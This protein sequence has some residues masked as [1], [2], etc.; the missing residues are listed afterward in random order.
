LTCIVKRRLKT[1]WDVRP[2][3]KNASSDW[4]LIPTLSNDLETIP[5]PWPHSGEA[6]RGLTRIRE[7]SRLTCIVKR[8]LKTP[9][10]VRPLIKKRNW[11]RTGNRIHGLEISCQGGAQTYCLPLVEEGYHL[12]GLHRHKRVK[13]RLKTPWDVRPLIKKRNWQRTGNRRS[14]LEGGCTNLLST[15]GRRRIPSPGPPSS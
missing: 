12:P 9:W 3:I 7:S 2:L 15:L 1:P 4:T 14:P 13:R 6:N 11:Q 5:S 8:R 10:D